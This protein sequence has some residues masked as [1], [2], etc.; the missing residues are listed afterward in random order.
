MDKQS[1]VEQ[2][3]KK[4]S[5]L[6]VGLDTDASK[7]P[8]HLQKEKNPLLT[9]NKAIIDATHEFAVAYKPNMAFYEKLGPAGWELLQETLD[10]IPKNI[11]TIADA[12]R[13]DIGNTAEQ[14]AE[15]FFDRYNFDAVTI[16][17]YMGADAIQPFLKY[18]N[19][20][21]IVLGLTSNHGAEDFQ[22]ITTEDDT[23]IYQVV[24]RK[25]AFWGNEQQVMFVMGALHQNELRRMRKE[26]PHYFFLVPGVGAQGGTVEEVCA[27]A[28]VK[29]DGGLLINASRGILYA[30]ASENFAKAARQNAAELQEQMKPYLM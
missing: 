15:T 20:W 1:L 17:P 3:Q 9:F 11:F 2:I 27:S 12:K 14:Y 22:M 10:Y 26:F 4:K 30:D 29:N 8:K 19:K 5:M 13:G 25:T 23:H 16:S 21:T 7:I 6:C 24:M 18:K 28:A